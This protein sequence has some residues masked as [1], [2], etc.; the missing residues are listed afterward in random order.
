MIAFELKVGAFQPEY[1]G[2]L[3]FY[4]NLLND[5]ERMEGDAP[6][7]GIILCAEK[8]DVEVEYALKSKDNPVGVAEYHLSSRLPAEF[9]GKLPAARQLTSLIREALPPGES[10]HEPNIPSPHTPHLRPA[11]RRHHDLH[12][13][14]SSGWP[15]AA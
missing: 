15:G 8:D 10:P 9:K 13:S 1:A 12:P 14:P 4:L 3:D 2:K 5:F 7:I 11:P 6:S